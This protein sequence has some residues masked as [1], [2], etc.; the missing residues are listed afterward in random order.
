M[1]GC[2]FDF[3]VKSCGIFFKTIFLPQ[4]L[5]QI[6]QNDFFGTGYKSLF[7]YLRR[8]AIATL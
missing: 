4:L 7:I 5:W 6:F 2:W 1:C 3:R 8:I